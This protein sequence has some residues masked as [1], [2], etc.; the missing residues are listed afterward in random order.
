MRLR[1]PTTGVSYV[2]RAARAVAAEGLPLL[3]ADAN[4]HAPGEAADW[5][6][7]QPG[8]VRY[9]RLPDELAQHAQDAMAQRDAFQ[10]RN[11]GANALAALQPLTPGLT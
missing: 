1:L 11:L 3:L 4:P 2:L 9:V 5:A 10:E 7:A 6:L 8:G